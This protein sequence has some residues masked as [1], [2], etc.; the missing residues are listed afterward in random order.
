MDTFLIKNIVTYFGDLVD[1]LYG[2]KAAFRKIFS[3]A[4]KQPRDG[5]VF[6]FVSAILAMGLLVLAAALAE[7]GIDFDKLLLK[8]VVVA[9]QVC[10]FVPITGG[11]IHLAT[12]SFRGKG[13]IKDSMVLALYSYALAP[14]AMALFLV[15]LFVERNLGYP[16]SLAPP[17]DP[18]LAMIER[19]ITTLLLIYGGLML[20]RGIEVAHK[21]T[22]GRSLGAVAVFS[23]VL[24]LGGYWGTIL[25]K[26]IS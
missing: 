13:T 2:P 22:Y 19:V 16:I 4:R 11:L 20:A 8:I 23:L 9:L 5:L 14:Y 24:S 17:D 12:K 6:A 26:N 10:L 7:I 18:M 15:L 21:M 25:F 3:K 1:L